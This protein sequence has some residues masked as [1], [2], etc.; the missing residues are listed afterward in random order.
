MRLASEVD[1]EAQMDDP[2]VSHDSSKLS[3]RFPSEHDHTGSKDVSHFQ[4]ASF[5]T[6]YPSNI[7]VE[8]PS[9]PDAKHNS[10][11]TVLDETEPYSS[12]GS[13]AEEG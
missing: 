3:L 1:T 4:N 7:E 10:R 12:S 13:A 9:L 5:P 2:D 8:E 11:A 6:R